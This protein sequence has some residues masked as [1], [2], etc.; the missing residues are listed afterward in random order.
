MK[1]TAADV[2]FPGLLYHG[3]SIGVEIGHIVR[4]EGSGVQLRR[5]DAPSMSRD[6]LLAGNEGLQHVAYWTKTFETDLE[7][8][9]QLGYT[10]GQEGYVGTP[11]RFAYLSTEA[12]PGTMVELSDNRVEAGSTSTFNP[13]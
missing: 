9:V 4:D 8:I 13:G 12:H 6:F 3:F 2:T 5:N 1:D 7:R 10:I 11:G